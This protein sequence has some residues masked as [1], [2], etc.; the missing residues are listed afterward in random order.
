MKSK[1]FD[2]VRESFYAIDVVAIKKK[3]SDRFKFEDALEVLLVDFINTHRN[4]LSESPQPYSVLEREK[5]KIADELLRLIGY[6]ECQEAEDFY[7]A[8]EAARQS[9]KIRQQRVE[10]PG[11]IYLLKSGVFYK[12]GKTTD[13]KKRFHQIK[14]Q[15][16][17]SVELVR[18]CKVPDM[19]EMESH[20]HGAFSEQRRNGEWFELTDRQI[21]QFIRDCENFEES[22]ARQLKRAR[23]A[24]AN[25]Q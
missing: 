16:P 24:G 13:L 3:L 10:T 15:L 2:E 11:F 19:N 17:F 6:D 12:I 4:Y 20:Y 18:S 14:L 21:Q 22:A 8:K 25:E 9:K 1:F 23:E 7:Q 5:C